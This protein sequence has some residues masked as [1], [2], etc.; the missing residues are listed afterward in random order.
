[1]SDS[2]E[3][4]NGITIDHSQ[5]ILG[6]KYRPSTLDEVILPTP[7][8]EELKRYIETDTMP[9]LLLHSPIPGTGKTT[10]AKLLVN[11]MNLSSTDWLFQHGDQ[12][13]Q[14]FVQNE[15]TD[16]CST[17]SA[18]GKKKV[19]IIDEYDRESL[20]QAM[21][22]MRNVMDAY[23]NNVTFILT[24]NDIDAINEAVISRTKTIDY[25]EEFDE[26][27]KRD[28]IKQMVMRLIK[29]IK[30]EGYKYKEED[31]PL[32]KRVLATVTMKKFP[33][34]RDVLTEI[35][36]IANSN[37]GVIDNKA[38]EALSNTKSSGDK[39]IEAMKSG[40]YHLMR[41]IAIQNSS[42]FKT[43]VMA[44]LDDLMKVIPDEEIPIA[45]ETIYEANAMVGGGFGGNKTIHLL[46]LLTLLSRRLTL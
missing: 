43:Y 23:A 41:A 3:I 40:N 4:K 45:I 25:S 29:I 28:L 38:I 35:A 39:A 32:V 1:M 22:A 21:K 5:V 46:G 33:S 37:G 27:T 19:V 9:H 2:I 17:R 42:T 8:K 12:V 31:L 11:E 44:L 24:A 7:V 34:F 10:T 26:E 36:S 20:H 15:L 14:S 13:N 30:L 18:S 6:M 16:F